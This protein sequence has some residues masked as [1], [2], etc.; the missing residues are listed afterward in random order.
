MQRP[1]GARLPAQ[2]A[3][4]ADRLVLTAALRP[5]GGAAP[6]PAPRALRQPH[7]RHRL[8]GA[9]LSRQ[10]G[11]GSELGGD[12]LPG[13][14]PA[15]AGAHE[16]VPPGRARARG[17]AAAGGSSRSAPSDGVLSARRARRSPSSRSQR[18]ALPWLGARGRGESLHAVLRTRTRARPPQR[19]ARRSP[20]RPIAAHDPRPRPAEGGR[21]DR[22]SARSARGRRDGR[23]QRRRDRARPRPAEVLA[24]VG[25]G[26]LLR[27]RPRRRHRLRALPRSPGQR[28]EA[29]PLRP[30]ARARGDHAGHHPRRP[31]PGRRRHHQRR[32][33]L[34]RSAAAAR[35]AR[36]L[37]QRAGGRA[38]RPRRPRAG[39][40][41]LARPRAAR[42]SSSRPSASASASRSAACR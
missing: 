14:D 37:A 30:G 35:G 22:L 10:A 17:R 26:R 32:R 23:R 6:L 16:P 2:G 38:A 27:R 11:R 15:V 20:D 39:L 18:F 9:A 21:V 4:G 29:V 5:R 1:G 33:S 12:R 24:W 28:A 7:P 19:G 3:R 42:R 40:R 36:Q 34:P 41:L 31:R 25:L 13:R 8:R